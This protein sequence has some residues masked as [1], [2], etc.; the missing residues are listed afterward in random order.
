MHLGKIILMLAL[1]ATFVHLGALL[2][3]DG[4]L[5]PLSRRRGDAYRSL[6]RAWWIPALAAGAGLLIGLSLG[7][8]A[9]LAGGV[10]AALATD[11]S[12]G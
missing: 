7:E 6:L 8:A 1:G 5:N 3:A 11:S 4:T 9:A 10:G 2:R 12:P